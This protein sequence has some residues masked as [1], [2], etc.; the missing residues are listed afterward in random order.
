M[1]VGRRDGLVL[2]LHC[3]YRHFLPFEKGP[4]VPFRL[5][6]LGVL[7]LGGGLE[8]EA[9]LGGGH[10]QCPECLRDEVLVLLEA[11]A[12]HGEG[13]GLHPAE[14]F[15][16]VSAGEDGKGPGGI[17]PHQPVRLVTGLPRRIE[18]VEL[19]TV[20][21]GSEALPYGL[22][23]QGGYPEPLDGP[24]ATYVGV[25]VAL[26]EFTLPPGIASVYDVL[27]I[28]EKGSDDFQLTGITLVGDLFAAFGVGP[29]AHFEV[30]L[31]RHDGKQVPSPR[32]L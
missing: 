22:V 13:G 24:G 5:V 28:V 7:V 23:G 3:A 19:G 27:C 26:D 15:H 2:L 9:V 18:A 31:I 21:K 14:G 6:L 4:H 11:L 12:Y 17:D 1:Q 20:V 29:G 10:P 8:R 30:E 32:G 25:D 16:T